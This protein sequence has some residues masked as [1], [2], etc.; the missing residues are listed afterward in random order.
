MVLANTEELHERIESLCGR[1]RALESAL[2][3]LQAVVSSDPHP[4]LVDDLIMPINFPT[5]T[6]NP[7][8][9]DQPASEPSG[10]SAQTSNKDKIVED[11]DEPLLDAF[12]LFD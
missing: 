2:R 10:S 1:I 9:L 11:A 4:L 6:S 12:G 3:T 5:D 7:G 8:C